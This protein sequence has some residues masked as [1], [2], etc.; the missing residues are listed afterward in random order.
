M[1]K[2][3]KPIDLVEIATKVLDE[4]L[5][6]RGFQ[7][8]HVGSSVVSVSGNGIDGIVHIIIGREG[9][10]EALHTH[11]AYK[12]KVTSRHLIN[13]SINIADPDFVNKLW[14][15]LTKIGDSI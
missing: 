12:D 13:E 2:S 6:A 7:I 14:K 10:V 5:T 8:E 11:T 15:H 3:N 1:P 4:Q 9:I